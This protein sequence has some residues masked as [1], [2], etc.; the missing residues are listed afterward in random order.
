MSDFC[1]AAIQYTDAAASTESA[2]NWIMKHILQPVTKLFTTL[3]LELDI[4]RSGRAAEEMTHLQIE[5]Q[6][7]APQ[8]I[9]GK[10]PKG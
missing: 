3:L 1:V 8:A 6:H 9:R 5:R 4:D 2:T 7:P 10:N